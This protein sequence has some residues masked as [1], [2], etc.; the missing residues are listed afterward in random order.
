[1]NQDFSAPV[2]PHIPAD[3]TPRRALDVGTKRDDRQCGSCQLC[4]ETHLVL[5]FGF[6]EEQ[7]PPAEA[8]IKVSL[9]GS[10]CNHQCRG[11]KG[12]DLYGDEARPEV[13]VKFECLWLKHSAVEGLMTAKHRPDRCGAVLFDSPQYGTIVA[14]TENN[15]INNH[16]VVLELKARLQRMGFRVIPALGGNNMTLIPT[17]VLEKN[18]TKVDEKD[19]AKFDPP[20]QPPTEAN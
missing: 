13:C 12:C 10:R 9:P 8:D 11:K 14:L 7:R 18:A 4:C 2:P 16:R 5:P 15:E 19:M 1:M 6:R 20:P 17:E 3:G